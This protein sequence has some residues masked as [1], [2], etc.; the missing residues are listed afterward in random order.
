MYL[1][2]L[3]DA[4]QVADLLGLSGGGA[5][6]GAYRTARKP[7]GTLKWPDFPLPV[8]PAD[9]QIAGRCFYWV[10]QDIEAFLK[11][12]PRMGRNRP[13]DVEADPS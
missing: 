12:H 8:L 4:H 11:R 13:R 10:R 2:D 5:A 1:S 6:V 9:E 7:D 3:L